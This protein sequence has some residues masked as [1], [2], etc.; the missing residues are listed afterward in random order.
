MFIVFEGIDGSGKTT[1]SKM[2]FDFLQKRGVKSVLTREPFD[3]TLRK[4]VLEKD[5]DPWGETFLFLADRSYHV[6]NFVKP[7]LE[8]GFTVISDR[9]YL[10]TIAYQ[11]FG[12][13]LDI[14]LLKVLNEKATDGLKADLTF[15]LDISVEV[16][17]KRIEKSRGSTERFE[18]K[19]FLERV[20]EGFLKLAEEEKA[21]VL[22]GEK[23]PYELLGE[24]IKRVS[25]F[26]DKHHEKL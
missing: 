15:I 12:R 7:K 25:L 11:G 9:Y 17:L 8:E 16:A 24:I 10:S 23:N 21:V 4:V 14:D 6:R 22:N 1:L 13:G 20:R 5:L 26:L 3:E 2:L 19:N 18:E